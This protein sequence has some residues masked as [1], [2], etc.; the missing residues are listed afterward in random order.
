MSGITYLQQE[1]LLVHRSSSARGA[2]AGRIEMIHSALLQQPGKLDLGFVR[3]NVNW[4]L[5]WGDLAGSSPPLAFVKEAKVRNNQHLWDQYTPD[6]HSIQLLTEN[7]LS[8][9]NTLE[10]W[11]VRS[12]ALGRYLVQANDLEPVV[13]VVDETSQLSFFPVA[14]RVAQLSA[15]A[16]GGEHDEQ[17]GGDADRQPSAL[18]DLD[19]VSHQ[20]RQHDH[21]ESGP[22]CN[23]LPSRPLAPS[24]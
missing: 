8:K 14:T 15:A 13:G 2:L 4:A 19:A 22:D 12:V 21:E 9:A 5:W 10:D 23:D 6:A 7:H 11:D 20:E 3:L 24:P 17:H 1:P 16:P 18:G